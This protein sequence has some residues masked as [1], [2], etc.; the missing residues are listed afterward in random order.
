MQ[1][2]VVTS[3]QGCNTE[4]VSNVFWCAQFG[5]RKCTISST[6]V[7]RRESRVAP[8]NWGNNQPF[9]IGFETGMPVHRRVVAMSI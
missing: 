8:Y 4:M 7:S 9:H 2:S 3:D 5:G 1:Y 6:I